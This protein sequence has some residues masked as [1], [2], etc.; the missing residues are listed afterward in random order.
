MRA[1]LVLVAGCSFQHGSLAA[2]RD[3]AIADD[4][5]SS[6]GPTLTTDAGLCGGK[7]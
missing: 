1:L 7:I 2:A 5:P 6:D 4:S 3:D